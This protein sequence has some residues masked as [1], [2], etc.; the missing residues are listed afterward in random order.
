MVPLPKRYGERVAFFPVMTV[1]S[2]NCES[3]SFK[4]VIKSCYSCDGEIWFVPPAATS[5]SHT[6]VCEAWDL[7]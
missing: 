5:E 1:I 4:D 3:L 2:G 7:R 6:I